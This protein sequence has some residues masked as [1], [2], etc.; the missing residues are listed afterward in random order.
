MVIIVNDKETNVTDNISVTELLQ[1]KGLDSLSGLAVA[2]NE[3]IVSQKSWTSTFLKDQD[4]V[5][6]VTATAGG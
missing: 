5:L 3:T 6:I 4:N 1:M 2:I